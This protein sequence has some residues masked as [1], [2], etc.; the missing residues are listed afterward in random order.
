MPV[1]GVNV[2]R[3]SFL[4]MNVRLICNFEDS[5]KEHCPKLVSPLTMR[6]LFTDS[7]LYISVFEGINLSLHLPLQLFEELFLS[8]LSCLGVNLSSLIVT[9]FSKLAVIY[10]DLL[11]LFGTPLLIHKLFLLLCLPS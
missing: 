4:L 6:L 11:A 7:H 10:D 5:I 8:P 2:I 3:V 1:T 9:G